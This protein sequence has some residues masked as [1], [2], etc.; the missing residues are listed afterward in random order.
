MK[1]KVLL[2][3]LLFVLITTGCAKKIEVIDKQGDEKFGEL[4][5][6]TKLS[7]KCDAIGSVAD[8]SPYD[9]LLITKDGKL[10][11]ISY[12]KLFTNNTNCKQVESDKLFIRFIRAIRRL[13]P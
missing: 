6:F 5:G 3:T 2:F 10:Y 8:I 9:N 11:R 13:S 4:S 12:E 7:L 1:K